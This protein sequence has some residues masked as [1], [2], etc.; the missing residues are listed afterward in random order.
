MTE[1]Y[2]R[3]QAGATP[4]AALSAAIRLLRSTPETSAPIHW[5]GW[6]FVGR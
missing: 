2:S 3:L 1:F 5:A 4:A 6:M